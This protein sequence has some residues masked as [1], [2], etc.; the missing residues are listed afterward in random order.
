[1]EWELFK[2]LTSVGRKKVDMTKSPN[3]IKQS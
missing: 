3:I 2:K 1:M